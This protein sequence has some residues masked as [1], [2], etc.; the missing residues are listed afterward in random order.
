M[1]HSEVVHRA[2]H[3]NS[4]YGVERDDDDPSKLGGT[5]PSRGLL[6][7]GHHLYMQF[8]RQ[9]HR[10]IYLGLALLFALLFALC[11]FGNPIELY[12]AQNL[13]I[14]FGSAQRFDGVGQ[15]GSSQSTAHATS[16]AH[17][18]GFPRTPTEN[19]LLLPEDKKLKDVLSSWPIRM[20]MFRDVEPLHVE[21]TAMSSVWR[22]QFAPY[23]ETLKLLQSED[24]GSKK[25]VVAQLKATTKSMT[26][27]QQ[28]NN[29]HTLALWAHLLQT[30]S[31]GDIEYMQGPDTGSTKVAAIRFALDGDGQK[32]SM[33][34]WYKPCGGGS[35]WPENE[36]IA[37]LISQAIGYN[38]VAPA[39]SRSFLTKDMLGVIGDKFYWPPMS[40][41]W[42]YR[43]VEHAE[44]SCGPGGS[45]EGVMIGWWNHLMEGNTLFPKRSPNAFAFSEVFRQAKYKE[46]LHYVIP[47]H[48]FTQLVNNGYHNNPGH[49]NFRMFGGPIMTVDV[50]RAQ[51]DVDN[52]P[53]IDKGRAVM[54]SV[55]RFP[56]QMYDALCSMSAAKGVR[57]SHRL[58]AVVELALS[59]EGGGIRLG[60]KRGRLL[61]RRVDSIVRCI[62]E[63]V[64]RYGESEVFYEYN[65]TPT[66]WWW[67]VLPSWL[68]GKLPIWN[69][70]W[71]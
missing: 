68:P 19:L 21:S 28:S 30:G 39:V 40:K 46:R 12:A 48:L 22:K 59:M 27:L 63:C 71:S 11:W 58:G 62:D 64:S 44:K 69:W 70:L 53:D 34:G 65:P 9:H 43:T 23:F 49:N 15:D 13:Y 54:C 57:E 5:S 1:K 6:N 60:E 35:E 38:L 3:G 2:G 56:R 16:I 47:Y 36:V 4:R 14:P 17:V 61:D 26:L 20:K 24:N 50:D 25:L 7:K 37:Y 31:I 41:S 55:C 10:P 52:T 51:F 8:T 67:T 66:S 29:P 33:T 32:T 42:C 18:D 45:L